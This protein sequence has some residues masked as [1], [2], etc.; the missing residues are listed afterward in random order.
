[1]TLETV[2]ILWVGNE[3]LVETAL[4]EYQTGH[5]S[6]W[7]KAG[8]PD[9]ALGT[10]ST[11]NPQIVLVDE[12]S[13]SPDGHHFV[14]RLRQTDPALR[15]VMLSRHSRVDDAVQAARVGVDEYISVPFIH[16]DFVH[17][18]ERLSAQRSDRP[19]GHRD[20][21]WWIQGG[22]AAIQTI[23]READGV[24]GQNDD[25]ILR[26]PVGVPLRDLAQSIHRQSHVS[27]RRFVSL[28]LQGFEKESSETSFWSTLQKLLAEDASLSSDQ[29]IGVLYLEGWE[30]LTGHFQKSLLE[31]LRRRQ[32]ERYRDRVDQTIR[33]IAGVRDGA[34]LAREDL[35]EFWAEFVTLPIPP[36]AERRED[37]PL[38]IQSSLERHATRIAKPV[39]GL[40]LSAIRFCLV[41]A[42]PGNV[43]ELDRMMGEALLALTG[44]M[45]GLRHLP[46]S[47]DMMMQALHQRVESEQM[48]TLSDAQRLF[49]TEFLTW[50]FEKC[51]GDVAKMS[52]L[53]DLPKTVV[54]ER[55]A[56]L[57]I[58][59]EEL[60]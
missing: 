9:E 11:W 14:K 21:P 27:R 40:S 26:G 24:S 5:A 36:L 57:D 47:I 32:L 30:S 34:L 18:L 12:D 56:V 50:L 52:E 4:Q 51:R 45:I 33:V 39:Q 60:V 29:R 35:A 41:Y 31:Y 13:L 48:D 10:L 55:L 19:A 59:S 20:V 44:P 28:D 1:M 46:I 8:N 16:Q 43:E 54:G 7:K 38:L 22:S 6:D 53:M 37:I 42:W 58:V 23:R 17:L 2:R 25:V 15:I 3:G 49:E